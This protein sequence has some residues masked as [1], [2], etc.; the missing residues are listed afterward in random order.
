MLDANSVFRVD[1]IVAVVTGGGTG[2]PARSIALL[3][4]CA[5]LN[6]G[7]LPTDNGKASA[8]TWQKP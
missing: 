8:G 2:K 6:T 4:S 1:G 7:C 5:E 3:L